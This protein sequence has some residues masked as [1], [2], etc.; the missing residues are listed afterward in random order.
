MVDRER[1]ESDFSNCQSFIS[2]SVGHLQ[3]IAGVSSPRPGVRTHIVTA[4]FRLESVVLH[5]HH[6]EEDDEENGE[7]DEDDLS[8]V[9]VQ[10]VVSSAALLLGLTR[11]RFE[12]T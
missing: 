3:I 12:V 9:S 6:H 10:R 11:L 4:E 2:I 5:H 8:L 1:T 7:A